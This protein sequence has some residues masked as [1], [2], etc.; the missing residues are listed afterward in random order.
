MKSKLLLVIVTILLSCLKSN[1]GQAPNLGAASGFALFTATGAFNNTGAT[2]IAGNIGSNSASVTGFPPGVV[3]GTIY[4]PPD[5]TLA[6]AATDV[7]TAYGY[8]STLGGSVLDVLLGN[9]QTLTPGIYNTGAASTL[10]GNLTL[11]GGGN[12]DALFIIRIGGAFATG[13]ASNVILT[14]SASLCNV[15][16]QIGGQFNLGAGS[17]FRGTVIVDGAIN[18]LEGSTLHGRGL[19][20]AGAI[21]LYNNL[22]DFLPSAAENI[23]GIATVCQGQTG[24]S[25]TVTE[26][27]NA[28]GYNWTL[29]TGATITSGVNTNSIIVNFSIT[30]SSG[31]ISVYGT[32]ACGNG[33]VSPNYTLI[34]SP[35][36]PTS[37]IYHH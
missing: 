6:Q 15:Y 8:L 23:T 21:S 34:I 19:S 29:P 9:G 5:A 14:G 2:S 28:T 22:V 7:G 1:Y 4:N 3:T 20:R 36:P 31:N 11:D 27:N 26:L 17:V 37:A 10:N 24:I 25:Y 35:P 13:A 16:W 18:L 32:N 30:A 33:T 12:P